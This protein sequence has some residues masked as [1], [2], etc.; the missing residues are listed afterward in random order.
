MALQSR[1]FSGDQLLEA[2]ATVDQKHITPG[3]K[4]THVGKIQR[5]LIAL[6]GANISPDESYGP[7]TSAAVLAYKT[8]RKIIN[9][10]YQSTPDNIVGKMTIAALDAE[11]VEFEGKQN[12]GE[13]VIKAVK[14]PFRGQA[15]PDQLVNFNSSS[16]SRS[17]VRRRGLRFGLTGG[18]GG[19]GSVAAPAVPSNPIEIMRLEPRTTGIIEIQNGIDAFARC[20]NGRHKGGDFTQRT[21]MIFDQDDPT[22]PNQKLRLIPEPSGVPPDP[23][24]GGRLT[25]KR[26]PQKFSI[27]ALRPGDAFISVDKGVNLRMVIVEVRASKKGI[28]TGSPAPIFSHPD[29]NGFISAPNEPGVPG[30]VSEGRPMKPKLGGGRNINI[31]GEHETP[32]FEDYTADLDFSACPDFPDRNKRT[33]RP[34]TK[35]SDLNVA[36]KN[37]E[38]LNICI[39][40]TPAT[41]IIIGEVRRIA[42]AGC[43][44][45]YC[46]V[47]PEVDKILA[48]FPAGRIIDRLDGPKD[49]GVVFDL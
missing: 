47:K 2:A 48:A 27:D 13:L 25:L 16:A 44:F 5:A 12:D 26:N 1:L 6:D 39:R 8:K 15:R 7:A 14:P 23:E 20:D 28:V 21:C 32:G 30:G 17:G 36:V 11:M 9:F 10:S 40:N 24:F 3:A 35:D 43:R 42:A 22:D 41:D 29:S 49:F 46:N 31:G 33:F 34:W 18:T 4:G 45:T 38:A 19:S 37:G